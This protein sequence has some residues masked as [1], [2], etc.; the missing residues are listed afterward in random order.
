MDE[1]FATTA[2]LAM[3]PLVV[4]REIYHEPMTG[5]NV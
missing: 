2:T 4:D 3:L 1:T 5:K